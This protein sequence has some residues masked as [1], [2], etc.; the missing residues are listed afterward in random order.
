MAASFARAT[1]VVVGSQ[2]VGRTLALSANNGSTAPRVVG[3]F[4]DRDAGKHTE[5]FAFQKTGIIAP[6][7]VKVQPSRQL[8][9]YLRAFNCNT[10][11][12][13]SLDE[14]EAQIDCDTCIKNGV[15]R[16]INYSGCQLKVPVH[17]SC[18]DGWGMSQ[19]EPKALREGSRF[20][21]D[22]EQIRVIGRGGFGAVIHARHRV[23]GG[24]YAVKR[25]PLTGAGDHDWM[26]HEAMAMA[27]LEYHPNLVRYHGSWLEQLRD[28]CDVDLS[29][30]EDS[31][32]WGETS[33]DTGM[34]DQHSTSSLS[35]KVDPKGAPQSA[36]YIQMELCKGPT[37]ALFL[38]SDE[39]WSGEDAEEQRMRMFEQIVAGVAHIHCAGFVHR[40]LKPQNIFLT[41]DHVPRIGDFG[42]CSR[43]G[44]KGQPPPHELGTNLYMPPELKAGEISDKADIFSLGICLFELC[45]RHHTAMERIDLLGKLR[46]SGCMPTE[47]LGS[48]QG[49]TILSMVNHSPSCRPTAQEL[50]AS[51]SNH[52]LKTTMSAD[53]VEGL[54]QQVRSLQEAL[55]DRNDMV[56]RQAEMIAALQAQ[57]EA[58]CAEPHNNC[59]QTLSPAL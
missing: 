34:T 6:P 14:T 26:L 7:R 55:A 29:S 48:P 13:T 21:E 15:T 54:G 57:L 19:T 43:P 37:L 10:A 27:D 5:I 4:D 31:R 39:A 28:G 49:I 12:L 8:P 32:S 45:H 3:I 22:F 33:S 20:H 25:I 1:M 44:G 42:L 59:T 17:V 58:A 47:L 9:R 40:D 56:A 51:A 24:E 16:L 38:Q 46:D 36:L 18:E 52:G 2:S 23:D 50:L 41:D 35:S 11:V 53:T 30:D